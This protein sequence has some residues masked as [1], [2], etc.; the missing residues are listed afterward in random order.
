MSRYKKHFQNLLLSAGAILTCLFVAEIGIRYLGQTDLDDNFN[1][2]G[3]ALQPYHLPAKTMR[4]KVAIYQASARTRIVYD[5]RLGWA[6]RPGNQSAD[7]L[8]AYNSLGAR[9]SAAAPVEYA[10]SPPAD[11]LRIV[12][13]GDSYT[14]GE[15]V[16][17][18]KSWGYYLQ[19]NL[20]RAGRKA[21]VINLAVGAYGLDQALL[22]WQNRGRDLSPDIVILGLQMENSQRNVNLLKPVYLPNTG[23]P[24]SKPRYLLGDTGLKLINT[25]AIPPERLPGILENI[26]TWELSPYEHF[27]SSKKYQKRVWLKSRLAALIFETL[28]PVETDPFFYDLKNEP[29]RLTLKIIETFQSEVEAG[30]SDFLLVHMPIVLDLVN[31]RLHRKLVYADL[32]A[33]IERQNTLIYPHEALLKLAGK[34]SL[35]SLFMPGGH[36]SAAGN[37]AIA[38][39]VSKKIIAAKAAAQ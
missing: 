16:P 18:E 27:L 8:Y 17:F 26:T 35:F 11:T 37:Q 1:I 29:A 25:P 39:V 6:P 32:L 28:A 13:V 19:Q 31:L 22:R 30:R 33:A 3:R 34:E 23:L 20:N 10:Q 36:Y 21:E 12:I 2:F 5:S 7:G 24:F 9:V 14:H 4:Q 38:T 15:E